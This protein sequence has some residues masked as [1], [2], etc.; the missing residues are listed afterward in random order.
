M[1]IVRSNYAQTLPFVMDC[2]KKSH[3][4]AIDFE[5]TGVNAHPKLRNSNLDSVKKY[6][7]KN[8]LIYAQK[9][10]IKILEGQGE[11]QKVFAYSNGSLWLRNNKR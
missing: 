7:E 2:I 8:S 6:Y 11:C 4:I 10:S 3:F 5:M 9:D 1:N